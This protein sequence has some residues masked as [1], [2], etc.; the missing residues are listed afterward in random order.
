[1][2]KYKL[3]NTDDF[4]IEYKKYISKNFLKGS[5]I[6]TSIV[7]LLMF[8]LSYLYLSKNFNANIIFFI[9]FFIIIILTEFLAFII[10]Y[11]KQ[12]KKVLNTPTN[13]E[14]TL[15]F[16]EEGIYLEND[17]SLKH[18]KW[19]AVNKVA[20]DNNN[21]IFLYSATGLVGNFFYLKF[22]DANG[23]EIIK[24][25]EKYINIRRV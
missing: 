7:T 20:I 25:I 2:Y 15:S 12:I 8:I 13:N 3:L 16:D 19:K 10:A 11:N 6:L 24:D 9:L 18:V 23:S 4:K 5:I 22:F 1:M 14:V 17:N 21:L